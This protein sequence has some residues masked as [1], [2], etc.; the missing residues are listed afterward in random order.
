MVQRRSRLRRSA[1]AVLP[2]LF[3]VT[4][5]TVAGGSPASADG[6]A[7]AQCPA[8]GYD[9]G[10]AALI[11]VNAD[12]TSTV[13]VDGSQPPFNGFND[14]IVGVVNDTGA[15]LSG[16]FL[17]GTLLN[18]PIFGFDGHGLC[19]A[20]DDPGA[21]QP[22]AGC[23]FNSGPSGYEPTGYEGPGTWFAPTDPSDG[24]VNV[25][26]SL[27][28][29][30]SAYFSIHG[31]LDQASLSHFSV[32]PVPVPTA[33]PVSAQA[34][35]AFT[36]AVAT[37]TDQ[38]PAATPD[39]T[40]AAID[41]GDGTTPT[42]GTITESSGSFTVT[43]THTYASTGSF[44]VTVDV[45]DSHGVTVPTTG[46]ATVTNPPVTCEPG[47]TCTTTGS[48][49]GQ[50]VTVTGKSGSQGTISVG[51]GPTTISCNDNKR[52]APFMTTVDESGLTGRGFS[53]VITFPKADAIGGPKKQFA[54]CFSSTVPFKDSQGQKVT[55]GDLRPCNRASPGSARPCLAFVVGINKSIV[56]KILIPAQDPRFW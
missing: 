54:V 1:V 4:T 11:T 29:S 50:T 31:D 23:P 27:A 6:P 35:V 5:L 42:M 8:I 47:Q 9:T 26:G 49:G 24:L 21:A 17:S 56:E 41:W 48:D 39:T 10:C 14:S 28:A 18:Q 46:T 22:P 13:Q 53:A 3:A 25:A 36:G 45:T 20:V 43:G 52:H 30:G 38:D 32:A 37:F 16:L 51:V 2:L 40:A 44:T 12:G 19:V 55:T 33:V 34:S 15:P 7:F